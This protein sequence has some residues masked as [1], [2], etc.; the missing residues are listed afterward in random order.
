MQLAAAVV[1]AERV[2]VNAEAVV[3]AELRDLNRHNSELRAELGL[4]NEA[5]A[6]CDAAEVR[7][8]AQP[9]VTQQR[10]GDSYTSGSDDRN[11]RSG[12]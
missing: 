11:E 2:V 9:P 6:E 7:C 5:V 4:T 10:M 12:C 8:T 3:D 1:D